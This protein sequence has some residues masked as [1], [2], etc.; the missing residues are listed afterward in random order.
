MR[1]ALERD[2]SRLACVP[3]A[4]RRQQC[5]CRTA[6]RPPSRPASIANLAGSVTLALALC[7]SGPFRRVQRGR[8]RSESGAGTGGQVDGSRCFRGGDVAVGD[9]EPGSGASRLCC[10]S[11]L[12]RQLVLGHSPHTGRCGPCATGGGAKLNLMS[13]M[14]GANSFAGESRVRLRIRDSRAR[15]FAF[16]LI[17]N[18]R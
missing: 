15:R 8:S 6:N 18:A 12:N 4:R 11:D 1:R 17:V 13:Y 14:K 3:R 16:A 5:P 7:P 2:I 9:T 10:R